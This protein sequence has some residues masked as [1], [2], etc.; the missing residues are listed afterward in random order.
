MSFLKISKLADKFAQ[1]QSPEQA[2][3]REKAMED[4]DKRNEAINKIKQ[5]LSGI[6]GFDISNELT[7]PEFDFLPSVNGVSAKFQFSKVAKPK[8]D[9][10]IAEYKKTNPGYSMPNLMKLLIKRYTGGSQVE[11]TELF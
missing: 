4:Q 7:F 3:D 2:A 1:Y 11:A 5:D 8:V 9:A 10:K 6:L